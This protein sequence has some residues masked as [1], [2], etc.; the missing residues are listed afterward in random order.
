VE[1]RQETDH[2]RSGDD[3]EYTAQAVNSDPG[4]KGG[5]QDQHGNGFR[6]PSGLS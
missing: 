2:A 6:L 3:Q 5:G 1:K 4:Q